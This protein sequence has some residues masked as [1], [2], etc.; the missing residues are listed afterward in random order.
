MTAKLRETA[1]L[2]LCRETK[3]T[4]ILGLARNER[5]EAS[6]VVAVDGACYVIFDNRS[7]IG[8]FGAGLV[9]A[10]ERCQLIGSNWIET[11][12]T[13]TSPTTR[14]LAGSTS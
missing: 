1:A 8:S 11:P 12:G 9:P 10:D 3:A 7:E 6:G 4:E 5:F 2:E 13:R 14:G